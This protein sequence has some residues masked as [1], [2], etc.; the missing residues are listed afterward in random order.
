M[1]MPRILQ[2]APTLVGIHREDLHLEG[3]FLDMAARFA[4]L[5]GTVLLTG[6]G[7]PDSARWHVLGTLPW[8]TL[9]AR[10]GG[11]GRLTIDGSTAEFAGDPFAMLRSV[12]RRF[13]LPHA[14]AAATPSATSTWPNTWVR[15]S[16]C[17]PYRPPGSTAS[18]RRSRR[19]SRW[20]RNTW[21]R[22]VRSSRPAPT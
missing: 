13:S 22:S 15:T 3:E 12:L 11:G 18:G 20:R 17:L 10:P 2:E 6:E 7:D 5:P 19:S 8:L 4:P 1:T 16:P 9:A 21:Q 14:P